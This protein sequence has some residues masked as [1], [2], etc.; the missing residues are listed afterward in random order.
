MQEF[1]VPIFGAGKQYHFPVYFVSFPLG[2]FFCSTNFSSYFSFILLLIY[3][4][5]FPSASSGA[6]RPTKIPTLV[7]LLLYQSYT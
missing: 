6:L 2:S 3:P 4:V 7:E 1:F 5:A